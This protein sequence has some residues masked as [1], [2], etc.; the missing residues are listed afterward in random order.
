MKNAIFQ[1]YL[2]HNGVG[3]HGAEYPDE[4]PDW[5]QRSVSYFSKYAENHGADYHFSTDSFVNASD[6]H[7]EAIRTYKDPLFD[8]YDKVLFL[9][10]D[11]MP[12]NMDANIFDVDVVDIAGWSEWRHPDLA[13][14][15]NYRSAA[16]AI[17]KRYTAFG[18]PMVNSSRHPSDIRMLNT[19]VL[20]WSKQGRLKAR[21]SFDDHEKWFN[22]QNPILD[23]TLDSKVVGHSSLCLDQVYLNAMLNKFKFNVTEL[24]MEWN[25][26]PTKDE[27]RTCN[28]AHYLGQFRPNLVK[29]FKELE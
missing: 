8:Q 21:E 23:P 7:F 26:L 28:F 27:N 25:R 16:A 11:V 17:H 9:D 6:N 12:H 24:P 19:G 22:Y 29:N 3:K 2:S 18:A 20:L 15:V 1:Y 5:A 10:V 4:T 13:V 14:S